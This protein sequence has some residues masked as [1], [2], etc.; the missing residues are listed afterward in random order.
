MITQIDSRM[1]HRLVN[2]QWNTGKGKKLSHE[3]CKICCFLKLLKLLVQFLTEFSNSWFN[4]KQ[5]QTA[6]QLQQLPTY[7]V[8]DWILLYKYHADFIILYYFLS[9]KS[10]FVIYKYT[11]FMSHVLFKMVFLCIYTH[12]SPQTQQHKFYS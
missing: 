4:Y 12:T 6:L 11:L 10:F 2:L 3:L 5:L 1:K 9:S 8:Y 7:S